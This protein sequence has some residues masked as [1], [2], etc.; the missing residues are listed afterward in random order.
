[1]AKQHEN[2]KNWGGKKREND[3]SFHLQMHDDY[4]NVC[5]GI[6]KDV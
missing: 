6:R 2:E 1:M 3:F 5:S 4:G